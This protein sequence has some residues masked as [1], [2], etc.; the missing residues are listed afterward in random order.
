M[1]LAKKINKI[2]ETPGVY[3]FLGKNKKI[4][5]IGKAK[6]LKR[7]VK[8]YFRSGRPRDARLE[9]LVSEVR[10]IKIV[11]ASSEAEALIY[12][13]GL[14][15]DHSPR[16]NIELK[17]DKSYPFLKL[18]LSEEYP[19]VFL[20]R[21]KLNDGAVYYGPYVN[22]GLLKEAISF[23]K[24]VFPLRSCRR[25]KKKVCLEY[26]IA[27]CLGPCERKTTKKAKNEL[28]IIRCRW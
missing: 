15:K 25:L 22:A 17:D 16:F 5:Y 6:K 14:I 4:N 27:Q 10:D 24:R 11:R 7:R 23:M 26:H 19:R 8:S 28:D 1:D 12:E 21:R 2:P 20:T 3:I 13:A 18:T 9:L